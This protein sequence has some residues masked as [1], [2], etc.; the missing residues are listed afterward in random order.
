M[1]WGRKKNRVQNLKK[2]SSH[3]PR[4]CSFSLSLRRF[5][6]HQPHPQLLHHQLH[7]SKPPTDHREPPWTFLSPLQTGFFF[8]PQR[9]H[10]PKLSTNAAISLFSSTTRPLPT[11]RQARDNSFFSFAR[12]PPTSLRRLRKVACRT[13]TYCSRSAINSS[14]TWAG[15]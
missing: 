9:L 5:N 8:L 13:W 7:H 4:F 3:Y 11:S 12:S 10:R 14:L 2:T 1:A 15:P 6:H